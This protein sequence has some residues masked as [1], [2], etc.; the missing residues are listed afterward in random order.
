M[1]K[2]KKFSL[3]H[4]SDR[5]LN[6]PFLPEYD[7][8][9]ENEFSEEMFSRNYQWMNKQNQEQGGTV[10]QNS[11]SRDQA[12]AGEQNNASLGEHAAEPRNWQ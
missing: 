8:E 9:Y 3:F 1:R 10:T 5:N 2:R 12:R 4:N 6:D 11:Q 7:N